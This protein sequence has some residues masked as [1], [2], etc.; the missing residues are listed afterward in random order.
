MPRTSLPNV[1]RAY[2]IFQQDETKPGSWSGDKSLANTRALFESFKSESTLDEQ[3]LFMTRAL[4]YDE[5]NYLAWLGASIL[6]NSMGDEKKAEE[7]LAKCNQ[8]LPP[9]EA[10]T[11]QQIFGGTT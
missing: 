11:G 9:A 8:L 10:L 7:F 4:D 1:Y 3:L 6:M 5:S 2:V